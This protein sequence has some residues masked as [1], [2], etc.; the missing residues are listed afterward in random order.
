MGRSSD[1]NRGWRGWFHFLPICSRF[2]T[3]L[4]L[5]LFV[6][7]YLVEAEEPTPDSCGK[8]ETKTEQGCAKN[9]RIVHRTQPEYPKEARKHRVEGSVTLSAR[10][11]VD[12][13]VDE[14]KTKNIQA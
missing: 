4:M 12:G 6:A 5:S 3:T 2:A 11:T 13:T 14:I 7:S 1:R 9:P 8:N 10:V